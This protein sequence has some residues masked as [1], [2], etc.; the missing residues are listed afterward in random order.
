MGEEA[1]SL[2][3]CMQ[4]EG[5]AEVD[6]N[7]MLNTM[8]FNDTTA[9]GSRLQAVIANDIPAMNIEALVLFYPL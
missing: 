6:I 7:V 9:K 8:S 2:S 1:T 3:V 4:K 5:K